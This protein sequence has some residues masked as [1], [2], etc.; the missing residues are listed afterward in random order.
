M[1][2]L[3]R[4]RSTTVNKKHKKDHL[5]DMK[6]HLE[7]MKNHLEDMKNHLED[8]KIKSPINPRKINN[9]NRLPP[10]EH[11]KCYPMGYLYSMRYLYPM[12]H[13]K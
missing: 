6:N 13:L 5:E 2:V 1:I 8:M 10:I 4:F 3:F 7:D 12:N 9:L 11:L